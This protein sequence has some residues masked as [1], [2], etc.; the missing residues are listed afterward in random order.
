MLHPIGTDPVRENDLFELRW[1]SSAL[2]AAIK[3]SLSEDH[4]LFAKALAA[5]DEDSLLL[6]LW[7]DV[8]KLPYE[9]VQ[10]MI[11]YVH[12]QRGTWDLEAFIEDPGDEE[13]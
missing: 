7:R 2:T 12:R 13:L 5:R 6:D 1:W 4:A 10:E 3:E 8:A 11:D 9:V